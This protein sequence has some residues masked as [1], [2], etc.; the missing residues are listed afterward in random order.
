VGTE[1]GLMGMEMGKKFMAY[2]EMCRNED[3]KD[4]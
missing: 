4:S 1:R 2:L 3:R